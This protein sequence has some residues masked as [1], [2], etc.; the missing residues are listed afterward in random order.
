MDLRPYLRSIRR[1]PLLSRTGEHRL[2]QESRLGDEASRRAL[3][4]ANLRL[5]V[6]IVLGYRP[7][8]M[9]EDLVSEGNIGLMEAARRFDPS[10]G[11]AFASYAA[12]WIRK[13]VVASLERNAAQSSFPVPA[14]LGEPARECGRPKRVRLASLDSD[15][16]DSGDSRGEA[17]PRQEGPG[18]E[19]TA[20]ERDLEEALRSVLDRMPETERRL[21]LSRFGLDGGPVRT[22]KE[23]GAELGCTRERARQIE[24]RALERARRL[25]EA[26]RR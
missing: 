19:D 24:Q 1:Y 17:G 9:V 3:V 16:S 13:F 2:A 4:E 21:L 12:W 11:V 20:L 6:K 18:P 7:S 8:G 25:L 15:L 10:R 14:Q 23:I 5:V 22:L 26:R